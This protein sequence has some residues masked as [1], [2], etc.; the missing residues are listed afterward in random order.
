MSYLSKRGPVYYFRRVIPSELQAIIGR[1][2]FVFSLGTKDREEA[3]RL[4]TP[5]I[6]ATDA[7]LDAARKALESDP[8]RSATQ[9]AATRSK[10]PA[11]LKRE[12]ARWEWEQELAALADAEQFNSD[13]ELEALEPVMD[14]IASGGVPDASPA[15]L[16]RAGQLLALHERQ[17]HK[18]VPIDQADLAEL[19][20]APQPVIVATPVKENTLTALY[21]RWA[22]SGAANAKT[23]SR[24]R[25]KVKELV[26]HLGHDDVAKV[27]RADL[28]G[29]IES[30]VAKGLAKKTIAAGYVPAIRVPFT[31]AFEDGIIEV[32]PASALKVRAPKAVKLRERDLTDDE[33]ATILTA[34]L[35]PQ[36]AGLADHHAR[37][38]RWVPWLCAY[39]GARVGEITQLRAMDIQQEAGIWFIHIT[40]DAGS[41]K[42]AEARKVPLHSHL[43]EQGFIKLAKAGDATPLF[44]RNGAGNEINPASKVRAGDL[45]KWVRTLGVTAPQPNHGWRHRFK[46]QAFAVNMD[47]EA[48]DIAQGHV[49]RAEAGKYGQ[50]GLPRLQVEIEKLRRYDLAIPKPSA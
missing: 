46:T 10:S 3:K 43:I 12:R 33:A 49:P 2:E 23:V 38:R 20:P 25:S 37:A 16:A 24:W 17:L 19:E 31:T 48:A 34:A 39:T 5:H 7:Q 21:E 29:W 22:L 27:R 50:R 44:Y 13:M 6:L 15:D 41:V 11:A 36:P 26:E 45:A 40:P 32:N 28:N 18:P 9:V 14:A 47:S 1:R 30:L 8:A 35:G 4:R 42:N